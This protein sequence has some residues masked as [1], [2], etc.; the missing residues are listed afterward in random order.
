MRLFDVSGRS[1]CSLPVAA[2]GLTANLSVRDVNSGFF[3]QREAA[4]WL[5]SSSSLHR[6]RALVPLFVYTARYQL[7]TSC[8]KKAL[9]AVTTHRQGGA[10]NWIRGEEFETAKVRGYNGIITVPRRSRDATTRLQWGFVPKSDY[11][12]FC[13]I[14]FMTNICVYIQAVVYRIYVYTIKKLAVIQVSLWLCLIV[15]GQCSAL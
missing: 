6:Q 5:A 7:V 14:F 13:L 15:S 1:W 8:K 4:R 3:F 2:A 11:S 9:A 10:C 12:C